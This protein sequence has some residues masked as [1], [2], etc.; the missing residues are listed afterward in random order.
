MIYELILPGFF[1]VQMVPAKIAILTINDGVG[2]WSWPCES[3]GVARKYLY[4]WVK[5]RWRE[6][7]PNISIKSYS[8]ANAI[9]KFFDFVP[10]SDYEIESLVHVRTARDAEN[11]NWL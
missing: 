11:E 8:H 6:T 9:D 4:R 10:D 5:E 7:F 3:V 1:T 2:E